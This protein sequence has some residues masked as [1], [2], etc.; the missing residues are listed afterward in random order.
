M[1]K[2]YRNL[3]RDYI[4][5]KDFLIGEDRIFSDRT[6]IMLVVNSLL[7]LGYKQ[8]EISAII[9]SLLG[10]SL[11]VIWIYIAHRSLESHQF[12]GNQMEEIEK[13]WYGNLWACK[14]G[15][16]SMKRSENTKLIGKFDLSSTWSL[17]RLLPSLFI[18]LWVI[19][20]IH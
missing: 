2:K 11:D 6:Q 5:L 16:I 18:L 15:L 1:M 13:K 3:N 4:V 12:W 9:I 10:I 8:G 19:L 14:K 7:L 17:A 20:F